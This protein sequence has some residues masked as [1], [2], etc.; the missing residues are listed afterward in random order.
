MARQITLLDD[1]TGDADESVKTHIFMVDGSYFEIDLS[2]D[3]AKKLM[4]ALKRFSDKGRSI[5]RVRAVAHAA[6]GGPAGT[7]P[8]DQDSAAIRA[9][10][11]ENHPEL[12]SERG[13]L[14]QEAK[15]TYAKAHADD[16]DGDKS[17]GDGN[18]DGDN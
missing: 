2:D 11:K 16:S 13:R 9:W 14:S 1:F 7:S 6:H 8:D 12:V 4:S 18:S 5:S 10:V 3:N 17:D 15:D